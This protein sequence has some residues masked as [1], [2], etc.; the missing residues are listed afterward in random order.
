MKEVN[1]TCVQCPL[2]CK[3]KVK[4]DDAG[5][6]LDILGNRCNRGKEYAMQEVV[7]PKRVIPTN[8][9]VINGVDELVSVKTTNPVPKR[10]MWEIMNIIK[11]TEV[12]APVK[13][14]QVIIKDILKTGA[15]I[16]A[17]REVERSK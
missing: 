6:V 13:I 16:V 2:G 9:K 17:T 12:E 3:L 10:L 8:V 1:L 11:E 7:D 14:G 5:V 15:D 4:M